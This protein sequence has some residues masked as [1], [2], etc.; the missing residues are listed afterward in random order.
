MV[1]MPLP[2][3]RAATPP[4]LQAEDD[5][6]EPPAKRQRVGAS[7]D[8]APDFDTSL[9]EQ[10]KHEPKARV[11]APPLLTPA[12]TPSPEQEQP[13]DLSGAQE[14]DPLAVSPPPAS[15]LEAAPELEA[16]DQST[17]YLPKLEPISPPEPSEHRPDSPEGGGEPPTPV[18][19]YTRR[20]SSP[21]NSR[22]LS[23]ASS[24][25]ARV[26]CRRGIMPE[27]V[28]LEQL[29]T[30][31]ISSPYPVMSH[32]PASHAEALQ[33]I[34]G[35]SQHPSRP[36]AALHHSSPHHHESPFSGDHQRLQTIHE[37]QV[38]PITYVPAT[39]DGGQGVAGGEGGH[40]SFRPSY[41]GEGLPGPSRRRVVRTMSNYKYTR[42][43]NA[44]CYI[45]HKK[46]ESK[47]K[48][49]L[50][51]YSHTGERPFVCEVCG[52]GFTRGPNQRPPPRAL[53]G[54]AVPVHALRPGLP[55]SV[56]PNR[57]HGDGGVH[58]RVPPRAGH[59]VG[60]VDVRRVRGGELRVGGAGGEARPPAR[61]GARHGRC[62]QNFKGCKAHR[63][64]RHVR[65]HHPEYITSLGL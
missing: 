24:A 41:A 64:V 6:P 28:H 26:A 21:S 63:L 4:Q 45:C 27:S 13:E 20:C 17:P 12:P 51:M 1:A 8:W 34:P 23:P 22:I 29:G 3:R 62:V 43:K 15:Y 31:T 14:D 19:Q 2:P 53:R 10:E 30:V 48:L 35:E 25:P 36:H 16:K 40:P 55:P 39:P 52:I 32:H 11:V 60:R 5:T 65:E 7:F 50:H 47:Y 38:I 9:F 42:E 61:D 59:G 57:A 37:Q 18:L 44:E 46:Y 56:G 49:K 33:V 54:Q 58:A